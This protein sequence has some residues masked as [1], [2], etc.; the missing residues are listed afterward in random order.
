MACWFITGCSTGIGREIASAALEAGHSVAVTARNIG[1]V[2]DF[3]DRFG[4]R[5]LVLPLDVTDREQITAAVSAAES[6]FGGIDV[7]VNNAGYGYMAA[8]EEGD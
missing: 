8:V 5:A 4:D 2:A 1:S 3:A 7:L 6:A